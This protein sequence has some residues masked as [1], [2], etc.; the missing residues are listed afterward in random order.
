ME[1]FL[2]QLKQLQQLQ[3]LNPDKEYSEKSLRLIL[4]SPQ[5]EPHKTSWQWLF[6]RVGVVGAIVVLALVA[7]K[8]SS[9]PL[10]VAGLDVSGLRAEAQELQTSLELAQ[11]KE[12]STENEQINL[13]L[14]ESAQSDPG[15]LNTTILERESDKLDL[16]NYRDETID[17]ALL[18]VMN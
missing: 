6:A 5:N 16:E 18:E 12:I 13:A 8:E 15:H 14:R 17:N 11:V 2:K 9:I 4:A 10:K 1:K 7:V 3:D